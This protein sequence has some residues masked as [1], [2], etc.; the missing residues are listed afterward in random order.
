M[1]ASLKLLLVAPFIDRK[2][3]GESLSSF[4]WA[5][6]LAARHETT[7]LTID[8]PG[9]DFGELPRTAKVVSF[10]ESR[11]GRAS[12]RMKNRIGRALYSK[13]NISYWSF[14]ASARKWIE[15][16]ADE[17]DVAHLIGPLA[18][19]Y[20]APFTGVRLRPD[21]KRVIGPVGG[22]LGTPDSMRDEV[23]GG[24]LRD[25]FVHPES[26][27]NRSSRATYAEADLV[28]GVAPYIADVLASYRVKRFAFMPE[29]GFETPCVG[30]R[31]EG[32]GGTL[33]LVYVGRIIRT[34][35]L[36]DGIAALG[37]LKDVDWRL[38]V[39]G[40]GD[41]EEVCRR[42]C[43]ELSISDRVTFRGRLAHAEAQAA[44][45]EHDVMLFPSFR[46]PAGN[47]VMEGLAA[48]LPVITTNLGGPGYMVDD[49]CG[50]RV[51]VAGRDAFR[52]GLA[53]AVRR[54][55]RDAGLRRRMGEAACARAMALGYWP[56]KIDWM[57][58]RYEELRDGR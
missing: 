21:T 52:R 2:D 25:W 39:V 12:A 32:P 4:H 50:V 44:L 47:A 11:I 14:L 48:G 10:A 13:G 3:V 26:V 40:V 56:N 24:A 22:S 8:V 9:A 35:G 57:C 31:P 46:E 51:E 30:G 5:T 33:R 28:I 29:M 6:G 49:A 15:S 23:K 41:R 37:T 53:E 42:M 45:R 7:V 17:F 19:R 34:K 38:T 20:P 16:H 55:A 18:P 1:T 54:L 58:A 43:S 36:E 27:F